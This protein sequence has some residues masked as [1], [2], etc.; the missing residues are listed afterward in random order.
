MQL[1]SRKEHALLWNC[2]REAKVW[3]FKHGEIQWWGNCFYFFQ[4]LP[5][6]GNAEMQC[7]HSKD[8][9]IRKALVCSYLAAL[10]KLERQVTAPRWKVD[11][12][13]FIF[14]LFAGNGLFQKLLG[15]PS[16]ECWFYRLESQCP[17]TS[18]IHSSCFGMPL[19][20]PGDCIGVIA[21]YAK[22]PDEDF[23]LAVTF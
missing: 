2:G 11:L 16:I 19:S 14:L 7:K 22:I 20:S 4:V 1:G 10:I 21:V 8:C 9:L 13:F 5:I 18:W 23:C 15:C 17:A 3:I 6:L 12:G